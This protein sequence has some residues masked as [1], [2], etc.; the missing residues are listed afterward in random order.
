MSTILSRL[1]TLI[2]LLS[3]INT[4]PAAPPALLGS[5]DKYSK[6]LSEAKER[7]VR[8]ERWQNFLA[9]LVNSREEQARKSVDA[10]SEPEFKDF[11]QVNRIKP[12]RGK[13]AKKVKGKVIQKAVRAKKGSKTK[14]GQPAIPER[15]EPDTVIPA[16]SGRQATTESILELTQR[17]K[18]QATI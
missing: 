15:R 5:L 10:L 8:E 7:G 12:I 17:M 18:S 16:V 9:E 3:E 6:M 4:P 2:D 14:P 1:R 13:P 11:C